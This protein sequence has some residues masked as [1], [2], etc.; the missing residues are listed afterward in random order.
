M[1]AS[2]YTHVD[3]DVITINRVNFQYNNPILTYNGTPVESTIDNAD[4]ICKIIFL[5]IPELKRTIPIIDYHR[6]ENVY[7]F[8]KPSVSSSGD[9][10]KKPFYYDF[11]FNIYFSARSYDEIFDTFDAFFEKMAINVTTNIRGYYIKY[12]GEYININIFV[13]D[14]D[15][16]NIIELDYIDRNYTIFREFEQLMKDTIPELS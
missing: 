1:L 6:L 14:D 15:T 13:A 4:G 2:L 12:K 10:R 16:G 5:D 9:L 3:G 8:P 7:K 11:G